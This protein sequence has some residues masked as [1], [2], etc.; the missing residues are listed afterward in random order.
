MSSKID[1]ET[2]I[3]NIEYSFS[4]YNAYDDWF[5][6]EKRNRKCFEENFN[7]AWLHHI[8]NNVIIQNHF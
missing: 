5:Y 6:S 3:D 8:H 1:L 2:Y 7:R 4:E